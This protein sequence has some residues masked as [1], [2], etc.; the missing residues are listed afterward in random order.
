[1]LLGNSFEP[2]SNSHV[3]NATA[4]PVMVSCLLIN[5]RLQSKNSLTREN[6]IPLFRRF[7]LKGKSCFPPYRSK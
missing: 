3:P 2:R 4:G 1:M 6:K 5:R 7:G